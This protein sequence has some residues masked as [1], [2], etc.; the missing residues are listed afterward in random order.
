MA[1]R[2]GNSGKAGVKKAKKSAV[3]KSWSARSARK[4]GAT[5]TKRTL[6]ES[7]PPTIPPISLS[8]IV[9]STAPPPLPPIKPEGVAKPKKSTA[10]GK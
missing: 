9:T 5:R 6:V 2:K 8:R 4:L 10:T 1:K 7:A 3:S